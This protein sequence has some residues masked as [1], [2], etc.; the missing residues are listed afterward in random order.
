MASEYLIKKAKEAYKPRDIHVMT[1]A[2]KRRNWWYYHK[3]HVIIGSFLLLCLCSILWNA[4]GIG[5]VNPD[6]TIAYVG[7]TRLSA[8]TENAIK[9]GLASLSPDMNGDG[10]VTV[11]LMHYVS[12]NTGDSD[13]LYYAQAAQVQ[14][15]ADITECRSYFF[16]TDDPAA[17]QQNTAA[18]R[19]LDGSLPDDGDLSP[20]G[21]YV[22]W[23][24]CPV[25]SEIELG[26]AESIVSALAFSRRGFWTEKRSEN[27]EQC[28][29]LWDV[30]TEGAIKK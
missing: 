8:E 28:D 25:L 3:Y 16:L 23:G 18:L 12:V 26:D 9:A 19:N 29:L 14:L 4:L 13:T 2:E 6:Y 20:D 1:E 15:V 10:K 7:S 24:D 30:L 22:L 27:A 17:L 11:E 21:K 5:K